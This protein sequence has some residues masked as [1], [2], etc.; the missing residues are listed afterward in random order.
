VSGRITLEPPDNREAEFWATPWDDDTSLPIRSA[1]FSYNL[2][3][4]APSS[5]PKSPDWIMI[6]TIA[7]FWVALLTVSW[8]VSR[9]WALLT[10]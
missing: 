10:R 8:A 5:T 9:L 3:A 7:G 1:E 2:T 6:G 4:P